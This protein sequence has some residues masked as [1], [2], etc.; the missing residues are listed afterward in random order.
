VNPVAVLQ[1]YRHD[2]VGFFGEH[3][4]ARG[5][6]IRVFELCNGHVAPTSLASF[7]GLCLLGGP[8]SVNDDWD[9]LREGERLILEALRADVPVFGHCLGGQL[10]SRALG[11][12]VSAAVCAEIGWSQIDAQ[13]DPL[14]HY[15]L[16]RSRFPMFQ[17]HNETFSVPHG[18]R[19]IATGAHCRH[20]AFAIG[21]LH[22]G[23]QFHC[24]IDRAKIESWMRAPESD[25]IDRFS[26]SPAVH[27]PEAIRDATAQCLPESQQTAAHLYDRWLERLVR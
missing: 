3:L 17:W 18:A 10:M 22:V 21:N 1:Y 6:P 12:Q 20:Q 15:W 14:S 2:G 27:R 25:D 5:V 7:G 24:E 26:A 11:G 23:V 16:G 13:G 8:M 9:P 19:L 4:R